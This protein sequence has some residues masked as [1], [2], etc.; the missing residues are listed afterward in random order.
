MT[1]GGTIAIK[2]KMLNVATLRLEDIEGL[3]LKSHGDAPH[4]MTLGHFFFADERAARSPSPDVE[5]DANTANT[6]TAP[7]EAEVREQVRQRREQERTVHRDW[8]KAAAD[9]VENLKGYAQKCKADKIRLL[10]F[11][12][13]A[14]VFELYRRGKPLEALIR[15]EP[16]QKPE[17]AHPDDD[18]EDLEH[19]IHTGPFATAFNPHTAARPNYFETIDTVASDIN[20]V[21]MHFKIMPKIFNLQ[22]IIQRADL[23][24]PVV[25][26][27][28]T[29]LQDLVIAG[30]LDHSELMPKNVGVYLDAK[31]H[32]HMLYQ[33]PGNMLHFHDV[34]QMFGEMS[35][36]RVDS[37]RRVTGSSIVEQ[38]EQDEA[39]RKEIGEDAK[40]LFD[41]KRTQY[42][43]RIA[44]LSR[45]GDLDNVVVD[46]WVDYVTKRGKAA[47]R[48]E[49][50]GSDHPHDGR[51]TPTRF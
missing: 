18:P 48:P 6:P 45:S 20:H 13:E 24:E 12:G 29:Q 14:L 28:M 40:R 17:Y 42:A 15:M 32:L 37:M 33:D 11:G 16:G 7:S 26:M 41:G 5:V 22:H 3:G 47:D 31:R 39:L 1:D 25:E 50:R 2:N 46:G 19:A 8:E 10:G 51:P 35:A 27:V 38:R 4:Y 49:L 9:Y 43:E 21:G 30:G 23:P 34:W 36:E 44:R